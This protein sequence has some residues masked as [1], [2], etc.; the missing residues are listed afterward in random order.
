MVDRS[1]ITTEEIRIKLLNHIHEQPTSRRKLCVISFNKSHGFCYLMH[2]TGNPPKAY[3]MY[4]PGHN[5]LWFYDHRGRRFIDYHGV[6]EVKGLA[7]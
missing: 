3:A 4:V 2:I 5:A 1:S 6:H 7:K